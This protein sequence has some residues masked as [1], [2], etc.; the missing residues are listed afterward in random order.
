M[1]TSIQCRQATKFLVHLALLLSSGAAS[2]LPVNWVDWQSSSNTNGF[3]AIGT[4]T[5][6]T[7]MVTVTYNNPR[8]VG[9]FQ[10]GVGAETDYW[11]QGSG[12]SLGRNPA[13]SPYTSTGPTGVDNIP[14]GT[15]IIA[16]QFAGSQTLTFSEPIANPYFAYVSLNGN[17]Y[18]FD[19]D[20]DILSFGNSSDGNDIGYWGPGTSTKNV[21]ATEFQLLGTGEP[22]GTLRFTGAFDSVTWRSLSNEFWNGF[23]VGI[24]GTVAE[25]DPCDV[26]PTL[27]ECNNPNPTPEPETFALLAAGMLGLALRRRRA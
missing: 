12:G 8:G 25:V 1:K 18:G 19:K 16:L 24:Q 3:T 22:H 13:T 26:D 9:F 20:F 14:V 2:A 7:S 15:D 6:P 27:P 17:G 21:T 4:I 5:T 10:D 11:R 23:T